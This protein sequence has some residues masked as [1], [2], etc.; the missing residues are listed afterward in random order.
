MISLQILE[1]PSKNIHGLRVVSRVTCTAAADQSK[2]QQGQLGCASP[3][4]PTSWGAPC[5]NP[6]SSAAWEKQEHRTSGLT[7]VLDPRQR[8]LCISNSCSRWLSCFIFLQFQSTWKHPKV[9]LPV[10]PK[11][12]PNDLLVPQLLARFT[13]IAIPAAL[14]HFYAETLGVEGSWAGLTA[15]Q[16]ATLKQ[17]SPA[18][19]VEVR[20]C[21]PRAQQLTFIL[22]HPLQ[23]P[24]PRRKMAKERD[25]GKLNNVG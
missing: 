16:F 4:F 14:G 13:V 18:W 1:K 5:C 19:F 12:D 7:S 9:N 10:I 24:L 25:Q 22:N 20:I 23:I 21:S 3:C 2:Q 6:G 17:R 8:N 15:Q 11:L